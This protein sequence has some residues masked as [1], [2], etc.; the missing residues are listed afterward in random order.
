MIQG[1]FEMNFLF[2]SGDFKFQVSPKVLISSPRST[3]MVRN[4][5]FQPM[6]SLLESVMVR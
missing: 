6:Y 4:A 1:T 3:P 2:L 5:K